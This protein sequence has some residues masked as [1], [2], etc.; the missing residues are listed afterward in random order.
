MLRLFDNKINLFKII[1]VVAC[2]YS[3]HPLRAQSNIRMTNFW[4]NLYSINPAYVNNKYRSIIDLATRKQWV[5]FPGAPT[6]YMFTGTLMLD[7]LNTQ[8][9]I[10][11]FEDIIGYTYTSSFSLS[12]AYAVN[13]NEDWRL[14]LGIAGSYQSLWYDMDK[15]R[16]EYPTDPLVYE[17]LSRSNH[18]N[19]DMGMEV[20]S[21]FLRVGIA[22]QNLFS[23]FR[24]NSQDMV[25]TNYLYGIYRNFNEESR[26]EFGGGALGI[27]TKNLYQMELNFTTYFKDIEQNDLFQA[28]IYYRTPN[29]MGVIAGINITKSMY[30]SYGYDF[31]VSGIS[32]SSSGTHELMLII[33]IN[34]DEECHTCY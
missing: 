17:K 32:R 29:E 8:F 18:Y 26:I 16:V 14:H 31:N 3:Q 24:N 12:Y 13:L 2:L 15:I 27:Q 19:A 20:A 22:S 6:T 21:R 23:M 30:L 5:G 28:G 9:G 33:R 7:N 34:K 11:A 1:L 25:N 10:K 4:D